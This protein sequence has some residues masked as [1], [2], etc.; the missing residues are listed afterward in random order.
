MCLIAPGNGREPYCTG[1]I[2]SSR[3]SPRGCFQ[4]FVSCRPN[5][6]RPRSPKQ[7]DDRRIIMPIASLPA[8]AGPLRHGVASSLLLAASFTLPSSLATAQVAGPN[9][10]MVSG[11]TW[12][13]GD[14]FLQRQNEPSIAVSTR[15]PLHLLGGANDYRTVDLPGLPEGKETGDAWLGAFRSVDGGGSWKSTLVRG[16]PQD[17]TGAS[18]LHGYEAAADPVVRAG[19]NGLFYYSR[20]V[21]DRSLLRSAAFM[22]RFMD[23]NNETVEPVRYIDTKVVASFNAGE[24]FID[25]P[26]LETDVPRAGAQTV[27]LL[28]PQGN[29][30][31]S[32]TVPCGNAYMAWAEITG[33]GPTLR[34]R[35]MFSRSTDCGGTWS[36]PQPISLA[37]TVG[38]GA[39][40]AVV[41]ATG[42]I[43]V[44]WRQFHLATVDC[45]QQKGYWKNTPSAW[46]VVSLTVGGVSYTK[47]QALV[48]LQKSYPPSDAP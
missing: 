14:P 11:T 12:P 25:K 2:R 38:Q 45:V 22:A 19:T 18:P 35:I 28:V 16:Y 3:L 8:L 26:W 1:T 24:A 29:G 6:D 33:Q 30:A 39:S 20:I 32:Q 40:I 37:G 23:L 13:D 31:V 10:N 47:S 4:R 44:A 7:A 21:F 17:Q 27:T 43:Y 34:T 46:P 42:R 48:I 5:P 36:T 15:N 41:P 9:V